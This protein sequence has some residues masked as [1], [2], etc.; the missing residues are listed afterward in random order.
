MST[1]DTPRGEP[2][3]E[4][5][6]DWTSRTPDD[7]VSQGGPAGSP[8][9]PPPSSSADLPPAPPTRDEEPRGATTGVPSIW[10]R[11][12][13]RI[14]DGFIF[15]VPFALLLMVLGIGTTNVL[16]N[17][18]ATIGGFAYYVAL[19]PQMGATPG[20]RL[21]SLGVVDVRTGEK[22]TYEQ[23]A[24]RNWW[25]LLGLVPVLGGLASLAVAIGIAVTAYNDNHGQGFH[26]RMA[27]TLVMEKPRTI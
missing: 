26:D 10:K 12:G 14:V 11:F 15:G 5:P 23:S 9:P 24:K 25:L 18:L 1:S 27:D 6:P 16:G 21:F 19:E 8:P 4:P 17:I 22:V 2:Q 13:A 7:S 20:K 3:G